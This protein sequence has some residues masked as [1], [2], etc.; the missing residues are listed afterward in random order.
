MSL[1]IVSCWLQWSSVLGTESEEDA[2][3]EALTSK[4][5][6]PKAFM[7]VKHNHSRALLSLNTCYR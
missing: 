3:L 1:I 4:T 5:K 2:V 7:K 6:N